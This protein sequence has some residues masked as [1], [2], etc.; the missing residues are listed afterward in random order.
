M[1]LLPRPTSYSTPAI[2][3]HKISVIISLQQLGENRIKYNTTKGNTLKDAGYAKVSK[4][5]ISL[6]HG[7]ETNKTSHPVPV[8]FPTWQ[9][10]DL[11]GQCGPAQPFPTGIVCTTIERQ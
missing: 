4:I 9:I 7:K 10:T 3:G 8:P 5:V 2:K 6:F 11:V 1:I